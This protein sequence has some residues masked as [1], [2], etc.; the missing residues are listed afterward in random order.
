MAR[1]GLVRIS[2]PRCRVEASIHGIV[3]GIRPKG[4]SFHNRGPVGARSMP[5]RYICYVYGSFGRAICP[6]K[7]YRNRYPATGIGCPVRRQQSKRVQLDGELMATYECRG[8]VRSFV[9]WELLNWRQAK[10]MC[11]GCSGIPSKISDYSTTQM[12][13]HYYCY[14]YYY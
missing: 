2:W 1:N 12:H 11:C 8:T 13:L 4:I 7:V 5:E 10:G 9:Q 3:L 14:Y 6:T